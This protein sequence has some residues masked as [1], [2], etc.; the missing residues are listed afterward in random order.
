[1]VFLPLDTWIRLVVW[2]LIG[3]DVY[4]W[5]GI[6]KSVLSANQPGTIAEGNKIVGGSGL[7]LALILAVVAFLHDSQLGG[8]HTGLF[9]FSVVFA[10]LHVILFGARMARK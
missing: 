4:L 7:V 1:M 3:F 6:K 5:Y 10:A 8:E 2:M 9:Y